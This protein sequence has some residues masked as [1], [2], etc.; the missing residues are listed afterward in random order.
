MALR[1]LGMLLSVLPSSFLG[2]QTFKM[3]PIFRTNTISSAFI[4]YGE[5]LL[6]ILQIQFLQYDAT[7][8][9]G[10]NY[11]HLL[12]RKL[13]VMYEHP[14]L[15]AHRRDVTSASAIKR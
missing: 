14:N 12:G 6:L 4:K 5:N 10:N 7:S 9:V 15:Y 8:P 3:N 11:Q 1:L 13:I 2:K